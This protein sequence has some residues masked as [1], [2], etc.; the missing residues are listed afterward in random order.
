MLIKPVRRPVWPQPGASGVTTRSH[1]L[2]WPSPSTA[3][4]CSGAQQVSTSGHRSD[5]HCH[6]RES[7]GIIPGA[8]AL[9][10]FHETVPE[11]LHTPSPVGPC[12]LLKQATAK[13][14][15]RQGS[16]KT[17]FH[18][19]RFCIW[20]IY[21]MQLISHSTCGRWLTVPCPTPSLIKALTCPVAK[22]AADL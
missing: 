19:A 13:E 14:R 11:Y 16:H 15:Y 2:S 3:W 17:T 7:P 6:A 5:L 8:L 18:S 1:A 9:E 22:K 21:M 20:Q 4:L 10:D 12:R